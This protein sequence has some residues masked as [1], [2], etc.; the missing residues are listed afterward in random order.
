MALKKLWDKCKNCSDLENCDRKRV[1]ACGFM[2]PAIPD[3]A[4]PVVAPALMPVAREKITIH[5]GDINLG[6]IT[7]YKDEIEEQIKK[8][9]MIGLTCENPMLK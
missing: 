7:A 4:L 1:V 8:Q 2:P 6:E 5:T 3:M 9:L